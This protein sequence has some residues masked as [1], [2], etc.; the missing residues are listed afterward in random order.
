[1]LLNF[2]GKVFLLKLQLHGELCERRSVD[3]RGIF[4]MPNF[5]PGT[6][7]FLSINWHLLPLVKLPTGH[8]VG[9]I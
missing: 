4:P 6:V 9:P 3:G 1:M 7:S 5:W 2:D 8:A